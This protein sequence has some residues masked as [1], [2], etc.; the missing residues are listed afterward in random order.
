MEITEIQ[1]RCL[2]DGI[3]PKGFELMTAEP[4]RF[5]RTYIVVREIETNQFFKTFYSTEVS[6]DRSDWK[7]EWSEHMI[8]VIPVE[9]KTIVYRE[10]HIGE[11]EK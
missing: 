11:D 10:Q 4:R 3:N 2:I 5:G 7:Y 1:K 8:P 9:I 6:K